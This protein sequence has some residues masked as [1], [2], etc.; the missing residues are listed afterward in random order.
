MVKMWLLKVNM[1]YK[2]LHGYLSRKKLMIIFVLLRCPEEKGNGLLFRQSQNSVAS[3][4]F[5]YIMATTE[6]GVSF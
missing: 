3:S 5:I 6:D 2:D 4:M 1:G